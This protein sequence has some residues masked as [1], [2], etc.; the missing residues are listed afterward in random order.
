MLCAQREAAG[1]RSTQRDRGVTP[2][3]DSEGYCWGLPGDT[4]SHAQRSDIIPR[5]DRK[6]LGG[7][8]ASSIKFQKGAVSVRLTVAAKKHHGQKQVEEEKVS[9]VARPAF[10]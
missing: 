5:V 4:A 3:A 9:L 1:P 10:L 6:A 7:L 8:C 2:G